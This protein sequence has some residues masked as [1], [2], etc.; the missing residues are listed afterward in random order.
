MTG[1][2]FTEMDGSEKV[3][4]LDRSQPSLAASPTTSY[5]TFSHVLSALRPLMM[6]LPPTGKVVT[7]TAV[8][9][10]AANKITLVLPPI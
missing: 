2:L 8:S 7:G 4:R 3:I 10:G 5:R 9:E 6:T 1:K